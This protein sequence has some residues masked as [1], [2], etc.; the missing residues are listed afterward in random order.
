MRAESASLDVPVRTRRFS[1]RPNPR[2]L[3]VKITRAGE[4]TSQLG[5][6]QKQ[7]IEASADVPKGFFRV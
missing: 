7:P 4:G 6:S 5:D 1:S 2:E 3:G